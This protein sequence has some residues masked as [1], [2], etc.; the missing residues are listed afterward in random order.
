MQT[1][2]VL[3]LRQEID[4]AHSMCTIPSLSPVVFY[5]IM[6]YFSDS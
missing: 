6:H 3:G 5:Y 1:L 2:E 4:L